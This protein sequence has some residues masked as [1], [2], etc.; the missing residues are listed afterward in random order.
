MEQWRTML[1]LLLLF[2]WS[3]SGTSTGTSRRNVLVG[4][5][6]G[7]NGL[8]KGA[9]I[10]LP[11]FE[12]SQNLIKLYTSNLL[13]KDF[14]IGDISLSVIDQ[15][16][17]PGRQ[18]VTVELNI[19]Q[20]DMTCEF[21]YTY[22]TTIV[23]FG[24][25]SAEV[26]SYNNAATI[27][28]VFSSP[29]FDTHPPD[30]LTVESCEPKLSIDDMN[31]RGG[32]VAFIL[33][34]IESRLRNTLENVMEEAICQE[35]DSMATTN[36]A[37]ILTL[38]GN[39]LSEYPA[40][41]E[42]D[43]LAAEKA[44]VVPPGTTLIDF[45]LSV[46]ANSALEEAISYLGADA[47]DHNGWRESDM[48]INILLRNNIL[49]DGAFVVNISDLPFV[50]DGKLWEGHDRLTQTAITLNS[51]RLLGLDTLRRFE[52]LAGVGNYTM[53]SGLSWEYLTFD[54]DITIDIRPSSLEDSFITNP[55]STKIS[56]RI[57]VKFGIENLEATIAILLA[58]D[59][60]KIEELQLGS[61]L[62]TNEVLPCFVSTLF[63]IAF[64]SFSVDAGNIQPPTLEGFVSVG[65]DRIVSDAIDG[66]LIMY[67]AALLEAVPSFFHTT[68]R[69]LIQNK[70]SDTLD[71]RSDEC[72]IISTDIGGTVDLRDLLLTTN[73]ALA[74][75]G[76]GME[77][78]GSMISSFLMPYITEKIFAT[79]QY[80]SPGINE[81]IR[82]VSKLQSGTEGSLKFPSDL[83]YIKKDGPT[84]AFWSWLFQIMEFRVFD[85]RLQNVDTFT[86]PFSLLNATKANKL[87]SKANMGQSPSRPLNGTFRLE[88]SIDGQDSPFLDLSLLNL[89]ITCVTCTA[90]IR[91]SLADILPVLQRIGLPSMIY[92]RF[93][94][95]LEDIVL[96][97][98]NLLQMDL[99][100]SEAPPFCPHDAHYDAG[101]VPIK[102]KQ[103][104]T[105]RLQRESIEMIATFGSL[106]V[107][108][109]LVF[110]AKSHLL[111]QPAEV[112]NPLSGQDS[113]PYEAN[114]LDWTDLNASFGDWADL[115]V[116]MAITY[117]STKHVVNNNSNT[118]AEDLGAN[119]LMRNFL[120]D[121]HETYVVQFSDIRFEGGGI[122]A[123]VA[124]LEI[125]GLDSMSKCA[126]KFIGPQT[127]Q[128]IAHFEKLT[129][130]IHVD[131]DPS[132]ENSAMTVER[133]VFSFS[134]HNVVM[135][136]ALLF[137]IDLHELGEIQLGGVLNID[138]IL[139]CILS[140]V[141]DASI[142]QLLVE[143]GSLDEPTVKGFVSDDL[144]D[145]I[146]SFIQNSFG[147]FRSDLVSA[148][149]I[150]FDTT[151]RSFLNSMLAS[152]RDQKKKFCSWKT[153][154]SEMIDFRDLLLSE[155][156]SR[157]VGGSGMSPYGDLFSTA[158]GIASKEV[159]IN[160]ILTSFTKSQ[161]NIA[162]SLLY[163]GDLVNSKSMLSYAG[164]QANVE[165]KVSDIEIRNINSFGEPF[166]VLQPSGNPQ[167]LDSTMSLGVDSRP[168]YMS[169]KIL[170]ALSDN[171]ESTFSLLR[172]M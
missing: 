37:A 155:S 85:I 24:R 13:C 56:E 5:F 168:L 129:M 90:P 44:L 169:A 123:S 53:R 164:L 128:S 98:W 135:R 51:V 153:T 158:V 46:W 9:V 12:V 127:I 76:S 42:I 43:S 23:I 66:F 143:V 19:E 101:A 91:G 119:I 137:A 8:I 55:G 18:T 108:M 95:L 89:G 64:S 146:S 50:Q 69:E 160:D 161:S 109:A 102:R 61:L 167:S 62:D 40:N 105:P 142:S 28:M 99:R 29:N 60:E 48:N 81:L 74:A 126:L 87:A 136:L 166:Q 25:G 30:S 47:K 52:P 140:R 148:L 70:L 71:S 118:S 27:R 132:P 106:M 22:D 11:D 58:I 133:M 14:A 141:R 7:L 96:S 103:I 121:N 78:Y 34:M 86:A 6:D 84:D 149:P 3:H 110:I 139:S 31:F 117:I 170:I 10:R 107:E 134:L 104:G 162:G 26:L 59:K 144:E 114:I 154:K 77:Q 130:T 32:I 152:F 113:L 83:I 72:S 39:K 159:S 92:E 2:W 65:I 125:H 73:Q 79:D 15:D 57:K 122:V 93:E 80:G 138:N 151:V 38:L 171:G 36:V 116:R 68:V 147:A 111:L 131:I 124:K 63:E 75:G 21:D 54:F 100:I 97:S 45:G 16:K 172:F 67:E 1:K 88:I 157:N 156:P 165:L 115:T 20:L 94:Q 163:D 120:L 82:P 35:L 17:T 150:V 112:T 145:F 41:I 4:D 49:Q 33:D